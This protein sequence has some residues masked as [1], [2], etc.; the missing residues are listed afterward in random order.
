LN[1]GY[2]RTS[3][4]EQNLY[5]QTDALQKIG[6]DKIFTDQI[7][8]SK[9][10]RP[11]LN[12]LLDFAR[13]GDTIV[14]WRLDRLGRSLQHLVALVEQ[15]RVRGVGFRSI[16]EGIDTTNPS[17]R[18]F[19]NIVAS[20]A[21]FERDLV[22]ERTLAGLAAAKVRGRTGGR[23]AILTGKKLEL[24]QKLREDRD[25]SVDE[26]CNILGCSRATFYRST[27]KVSSTYVHPSPF[28]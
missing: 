27:G 14:V 8:G 16:T 7:S 10:D 1:I 11:G 6:C 12:E 5:L 26:A 9:T 18:L 17:G 20:L 13:D 19:F 24:A 22:K 25:L 15:L 2:Q 3:T 4:H 21:E 28:G 23:R